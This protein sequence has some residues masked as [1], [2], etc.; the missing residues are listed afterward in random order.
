MSVAGFDF[1]DTLVKL[2]S[3]ELVY[4]STLSKLRGLHEQGY[5]LVVFSNETIHLLKQEQDKSKYIARKIARID[6]FCKA[7]RV[8]IQCYVATQFDSYRKPDSRERKLGSGGIGMWHEFVSLLPHDCTVSLKDS[9]FVGDAAGARGD[10][11]DADKQFA[12]RVGMRFFRMDE[13]FDSQTTTLDRFFVTKKVRML[14]N[15]QAV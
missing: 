10:Y 13:Y 9:F 6:R 5:Q 7:L 14:E 12:A 15:H 2:R 4:K 1:D 3:H 8:P 11:S